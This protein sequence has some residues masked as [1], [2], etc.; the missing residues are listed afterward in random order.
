VRVVVTRPR[1]QA[2]ELATLLRAQGFEPVSLAAYKPRESLRVLLGRPKASTGV[3]GRR[4]F[5]FVR[6]D[7]LGTDAASPSLRVRVARQ[8][9]GVIT[10][11]YTL[12]MPG[13]KPA[14]PTGGATSVRFTMADGRLVPE[15][16]IPSVS[17]RLPPS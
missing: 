10:L 2:D 11:R 6:G 17:S 14:H 7:Y 15:D 5:F 12:F 9:G 4:A 16:V 8:R 13:D 1:A 3:K